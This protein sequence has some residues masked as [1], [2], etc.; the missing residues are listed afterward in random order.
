MLPLKN[1][2]AKDTSGF[3]YTV[4]EAG[5]G[6]GIITSKVVWESEP[7]TVTADE[8]LTPT[9]D[10]QANREA[11]ESFLREEL[12]DGNEVACSGLYERAGEQGISKKVLWSVK[13]KLGVAACKSS[14]SGGWTWR[15][16]I[17]STPDDSQD[18]QDSQN[19]KIPKSDI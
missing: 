1:N 19:P 13:K 8:A 16:P 3:A 17:G 4:E 18:S 7:V 9:S 15:L 10:R 12:K 6:N 11:A 2:L 14:F 5:I